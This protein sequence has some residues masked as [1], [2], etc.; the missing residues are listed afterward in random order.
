MKTLIQTLTILVLCLIAQLY[1]PWWIVAVIAAA[2]GY[3]FNNAPGASFL[4]GFAA[5]AA[6]WLGYAFWIDQQTGAL[7]TGK[8]AQLFPGKSNAV[9]YVL[10]A[11]TGGVAGGLGG[12]TGAWVKKAMK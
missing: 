8:I 7:L 2:I 12:L 10:T 6:L 9:I 11:L 1:L 5:V 3:Q 4:A